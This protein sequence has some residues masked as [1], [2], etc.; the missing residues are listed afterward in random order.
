MR[1]LR[2]H[3]WLLLPGQTW[4]SDWVK[5]ESGIETEGG[6]ATDWDTD[7]TCQTY[8]HSQGKFFLP[9]KSKDE[10]YFHSSDSYQLLDEWCKI[11]GML[12]TMKRFW[13]FWLVCDLWS[14]NHKQKPIYKIILY[15]PIHI[16][17]QTKHG[18]WILPCQDNTLDI[19]CFDKSALWRWKVNFSQILFL[20][21]RQYRHRC[22]L[23]PSGL[24]LDGILFSNR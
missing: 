1:T 17:T 5:P 15:Y 14:P 18:Q 2:S 10:V 4:T 7:Q 24:E 23:W 16:I 12:E 20:L 11:H 13:T 22:E 9:I 8:K 3:A 6:E 21:L 19:F